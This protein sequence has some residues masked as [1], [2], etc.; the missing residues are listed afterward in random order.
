MVLLWMLL[1]ALRH[2]TP[3]DSDAIRGE[4]HPA[5]IPSRDAP[6]TSTVPEAIPPAKFN[7]RRGITDKCGKGHIYQV[8]PLLCVQYKDMRYTFL[9]V[10]SL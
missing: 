6:S 3:T 9:G 10:L 1:I 5:N 7:I 2:A 8:D 4:F